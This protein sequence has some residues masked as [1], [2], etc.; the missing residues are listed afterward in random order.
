MSILAYKLA[1]LGVAAG[2]GTDELA[3]HAN[4][5]AF[6]AV[7]ETDTLYFDEAT[8]CAWWWDGTGYRAVGWNPAL[9]ALV[10]PTG[11]NPNGFAALPRDASGNAI[12]NVTPRTGTLTNLLTTVA[13]GVGEISVAT[14]K[15]VLVRHNGVAGG[16]KAYGRS[17][18]IAEL[19]HDWVEGGTTDASTTVYTPILIDQVSNAIT[20]DASLIVS[21]EIVLPAGSAFLRV[22]GA[23]T[24]GANATGTNRRVRLEGWNGSLWANL[25]TANG[26]NP[27][28]AQ[29]VPVFFDFLQAVGSYTKFRLL[30]N[31]DATVALAVT[32]R[33][34]GIGCSPLIIQALA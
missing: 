24:F 25:Q 16:A 14:D 9:N 33:G 1:R 18:I 12:A 15:D 21:N 10:D 19:Y 5:A 2:V 23:F 8:G 20:G 7:G 29:S 27:N 34:T 31:S 30:I 6:P 28:T 4:R 26:L 32:K 11:N 17:R 13:G 22:A 3:R